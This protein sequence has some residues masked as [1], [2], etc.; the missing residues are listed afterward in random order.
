M[1]FL[2]KR[3]HQYPKTDC[4]FR[5]SPS[6]LTL[7]L[8][9]KSLSLSGVM[10]VTRASDSKNGADAAQ[11]IPFF[12]P[13]TFETEGIFSYVVC[14]TFWYGCRVDIRVRTYLR[15]TSRCRDLS[16]LGGAESVEPYEVSEKSSRAACGG[17]SP[18]A[19]LISASKTTGCVLQST[20]L[21]TRD[22]HGVS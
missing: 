6:C 2:S 15:T 9:P 17:T 1:V 4:A 12:C 7:T 22:R 10:C 13:F 8:T 20:R 14:D 11:P 5:S 21:I 19:L 16:K 3:K 18:R